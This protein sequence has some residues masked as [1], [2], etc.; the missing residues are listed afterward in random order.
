MNRP[1]L[2]LSLVLASLASI[3]QA[4]QR[5]NG[6]QPDPAAAELARHLTMGPSNV[7]LGANIAVLKLPGNYGFLDKEWTNQQLEQSG[8]GAMPGMLGAVQ[9]ASEDDTGSV[10]L[11]YTDTGYIKDD[12]ADKLNADDLMNQMKEATTK[13]NEERRSHGSRGMDVV[14][15]YKQPYYDRTRHTLNWAVVAQEEGGGE[16]VINDTTVILG[17]Q[18]ILFVTAVG[19]ANTADKLHTLLNTVGGFTTFNPGSDYASFR[20]GDRISELTMTGLV[21]GGA[22][23]A[24]YGA[25]KIGL[26]AKFWKLI[27]VGLAA[28]GAGLKKFWSKITG[29]SGETIST[30][31]R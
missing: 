15:W 24:A 8:E 28:A 14:G 2:A 12:D 26:F 13:Q 22:A 10:I 11:N 27:L 4:Q 25:V 20:S 9:S 16:R 5:P 6:G 31:I 21:T 30:Q 17:R 7:T 18:G 23:A 3:A 29:R 1:A 19:S